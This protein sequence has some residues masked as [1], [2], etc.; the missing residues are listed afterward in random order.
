MDDL[1]QL[2]D[3]SSDIVHQPVS[4]CYIPDLVPMYAEVARVQRTT[5]S[6]SAST[7]SR[8]VCRSV[9]ATNVISL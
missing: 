3:E 7:S 1:R 9:I 8:S 5:G 4:S 2:S 6:T